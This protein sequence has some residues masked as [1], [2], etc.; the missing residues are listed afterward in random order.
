MPL[1]VG[2]DAHMEEVLDV[3]ARALEQA[4]SVG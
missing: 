4:A 3:A 1:W 2:L